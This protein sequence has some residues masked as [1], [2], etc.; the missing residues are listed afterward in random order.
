MPGLDAIKANQ[1]ARNAFAL[2]DSEVCLITF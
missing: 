1:H 2:N